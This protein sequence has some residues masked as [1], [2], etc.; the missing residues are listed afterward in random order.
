MLHLSDILHAFAN[1]QIEGDI[2]QAVSDV[3]TGQGGVV[4]IVK[5][6]HDLLSL[7]SHIT[8]HVAAAPPVPAAQLSPPV[9]PPTA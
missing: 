7:I 1:D 6:G 3:A 5:V 4:K 8:N 9:Q 2:V